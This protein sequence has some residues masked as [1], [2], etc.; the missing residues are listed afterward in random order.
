[1]HLLYDANNSL[2]QYFVCRFHQEDKVKYKNV[3]AKLE[4]ECAQLKKTISSMQ[5]D[6]SEKGGESKLQDELNQLRFDNEAIE[7]KLRKYVIHFQRL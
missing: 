5:A 4:E 3:C 1:M 6:T 7:S 2:T